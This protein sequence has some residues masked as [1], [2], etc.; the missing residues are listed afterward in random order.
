MRKV[1]SENFMR[2]YKV[3]GVLG[4]LLIAIFSLS[5]AFGLPLENVHPKRHIDNT[6]QIAQQGGTDELILG[7]LSPTI[8]TSYL[9]LLNGAF[10]DI[11]DYVEQSITVTFKHQKNV[12]LS[13][14]INFKQRLIYIFHKTIAAVRSVHQALS[15]LLNI[16]R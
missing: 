7:T 5:T 13:T 8:A 14:L 12:F 2:S 16:Y 11:I 6:P 10:N 15:Y 9:L 3:I 4:L 1:E